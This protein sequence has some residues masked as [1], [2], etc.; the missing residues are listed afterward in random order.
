MT[1]GKSNRQSSV[2]V[3]LPLLV[4]CHRLAIGEWQPFLDM[5][6]DDH[7]FWHPNR[8]Y[9]GKNNGKELAVAFFHYVSV[10][11]PSYRVITNKR[12]VVFENV[13]P[14]T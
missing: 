12:T 14:F 5:L 6:T 1:L 3:Q 4:R 11:A 13:V 2:P 8:E 10:F 7:I 9:K